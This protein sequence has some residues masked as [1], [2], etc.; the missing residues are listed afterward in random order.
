ML[1]HLRVFARQPELLTLLRFGGDALV[2]CHVIAALY[3]AHVKVIDVHVEFLHYALGTG[4]PRRFVMQEVRP[5]VYIVP[6]RCLVGYEADKYRLAL[7]H[8]VHH[9]LY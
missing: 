4:K 9:V 2:F 5:V 6:E 1:K 3:A 7:P 8:V